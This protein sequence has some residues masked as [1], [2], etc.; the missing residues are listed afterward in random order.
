V[1][2]KGKLLVML[3][4]DP[5]VPDPRDPSKLDEKMFK[6]KAMTYY[7]RWTYKYE[8]AALKGAAGCLIV[9]ETGPAGYP[10]EVVRGGHSGEEFSLLSADRGASHSAV[11]A[12]ITLDKARA[13]F[14]EAGKDF[15]ALKESAVN[16]TFR[17][18]P[19][20][21]RASLTIKNQIR[22]IDS[23]NA[24]AKVEG[25]D[26][27]LRN[28]YVIYSAHWDHLGIGEAINGDK[29][30]N[31]AADNA[32]GVA[33]LLEIAAA[34]TK[35]N[36]APRRSILFLFV[37]A[38]EQGLL[39]SEYYAEHPL[40]SLENT[41]ANINI[42]KLNTLGRTKDFVVVGLGMSTLD[43]L[44]KKVAAEQGRVVTPDAEPEKG[45]YYRSDH[46]NFAKQGVP[47][48]HTDGG[49]NYLGKPAGW[50]LGMREKWTTEDYHKPSDEVKPY[51]DLSGAVEDLQLL[52]EVGSRVANAPAY[53]TW[54]P[55]TE[56]K[57]KRD[58]MLGTV[59]SDK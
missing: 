55:G 46:F 59:V 11:E 33:G 32:S 39:G 24:V 28:Q 54:K 52:F 58:T 19:L 36:P 48:L 43:D 1:D 40:Y 6:G 47:A 50:G 8:I 38:E 4:N 17:P 30:Y 20:A 22:T 53:P 21:V 13:L 5:P 23:N 44:V 29:I 10:W 9:H 2:V 18:V 14:A 15:D 7:G 42:D 56:F 16:R 27:K 34:F 26:P 3:V 57:A 49:T 31:G 45:F 35:A 41:A 12:W 51:W 37:T 25:R